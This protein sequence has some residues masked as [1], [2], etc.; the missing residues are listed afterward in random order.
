M[1]IKKDIYSVSDAE[2]AS[3]LRFT[4][5]SQ[6]GLAHVSGGTDKLLIVFCLAL[7]VGIGFYV[8]AQF[9]EEM[10][11]FQEGL[12]RSSWALFGKVIIGLNLCFLAWRA[13]LVMHYRPA[14]ACGDA[15]L[16]SCTVV[17]PAYNEG[18]QV[19]DTLRSVMASDFPAEKMQVICVDDGSKD[20]TWEWMMAGAR[21]FGD[22]IELIRQP[23][24]K[25]KR[26]ALYEGFKRATGEVFVTIDSDSEVDTMTLRRIV[27][28]FTRDGR[29]GAVAGNVRVLNKNEGIIPKML[30]VAFTY[31]FDFI[32]ASESQVNTVQ[33]TPGALSAYSAAAVMPILDEWLEQKFMGRTANIGEDRAMTN[34]ILRQ[35][36]LVHYQSDAMVYTKVPTNYT[37]LCKMLLRWARS[38]IRETIAL[39]RFAFTRFR[40]VSALGARVNLVMQLMKMTLGEVFKLSLIV[41][42][43]SWPLMAGVKLLLGVLVAAVIPALFYLLRNRSSDFLW[44]FPYT[45]YWLLALSWISLYALF[46][47]HRNGWLTRQVAAKPLHAAPTS[48]DLESIRLTPLL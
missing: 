28:V 7:A 46:T 33:C 8:F 19:L 20:D 23:V 27:S 36:R 25:G 39:S 37:C 45:L 41:M 32:R 47:P 30:D 13:Y 42:L 6:A 35:G 3:G 12:R 1:S 5:P 15:D 18:F 14:L 10:G 4:G 44:A 16:K 9:A 40:T 24:N 2:R 48:A 38:N 31:S 22:R 11:M 34:L 26:H 21:E 43:A 17:I 29:V